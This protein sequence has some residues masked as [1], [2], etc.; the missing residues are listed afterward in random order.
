MQIAG[1]RIQTLLVIAMAGHKLNPNRDVTP[2]LYNMLYMYNMW[3]VVHVHN[4]W[5]TLCF[6]MYPTLTG[7]DDAGAGHSCTEW[8]TTIMRDRA[9][10]APCLLLRVLDDFPCIPLHRR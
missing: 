4:M 1:S 3:I 6:H 7:C 8:S 5:Y 10:R 9:C 2:H